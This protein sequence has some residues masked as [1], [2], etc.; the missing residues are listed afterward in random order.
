M[1]NRSDRGPR[2]QKEHRVVAA[3]TSRW[4]QPS[5]HGD[6]RRHVTVYAWIVFVHNAN[7]IIIFSADSAPPTDSSSPSQSV[8]IKWPLCRREIKATSKQATDAAAAVRTRDGDEDKNFSR[9][10][11]IWDYWKLRRAEDYPFFSIIVALRV[12]YSLMLFQIIPQCFLIFTDDVERY[13]WF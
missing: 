5:R 11:Q 3:A 7:N 13:F 9:P 2:R 6:G 1:T 10:P 8:Y 4:R 12:I